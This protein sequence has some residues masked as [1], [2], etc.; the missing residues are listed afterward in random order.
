LAGDHGPLGSRLGKVQRFGVL[1]PLGKALRVARQALGLGAVFCCFRRGTSRLLG[2]RAPGLL[3]TLALDAPGVR[4]MGK[5][6][7]P[8]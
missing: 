5:L 3:I 8:R 1:T 2:R 7:R 4:L 6:R